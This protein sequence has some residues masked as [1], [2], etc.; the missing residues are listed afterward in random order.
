MEGVTSAFI[1]GLL[2]NVGDGGCSPTHYLFVSDQIEE[3]QTT[4]RVGGVPEFPTQKLWKPS[5][6]RWTPAF[7]VRF[8]PTTKRTM[9]SAE[10][11]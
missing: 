2:Q 11:K 6:G 8:F 7:L 4:S 3:S 1:W 10:K 9:F 5:P